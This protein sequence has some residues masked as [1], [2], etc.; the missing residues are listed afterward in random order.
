MQDC[1]VRSWRKCGLWTYLLKSIVETDAQ[2][3]AINEKS[4]QNL[5]VYNLQI[6]FKH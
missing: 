4:Q 6:I 2:A 3:V 5:T 1:T